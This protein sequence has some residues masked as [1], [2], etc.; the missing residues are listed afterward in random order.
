VWLGLVIS[1]LCEGRSEPRAVL[2]HKYGKVG[3]GTQTITSFCP[4]RV[5]FWCFMGNYLAPRVKSLGQTLDSGTQGPFVGPGNFGSLKMYCDLTWIFYSADR[6]LASFSVD[7]HDYWPWWLMIDNMISITWFDV[8][9][10]AACGVFVVICWGSH[11][12]SPNNL[13]NG[14]GSKEEC[15]A[16]KPTNMLWYRMR[17]RGP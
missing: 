12:G 14:W 17:G 4:A 13:N 3:C 6:T 7:L 1:R 8:G 15:N 16:K 11:L 9:L 5:I 2:V 10:G